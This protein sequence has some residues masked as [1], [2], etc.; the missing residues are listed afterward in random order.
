MYCIG[1]FKEVL[2]L[3][4]CD[5]FSIP[6]S[7]LY[8]IQETSCDE[9]PVDEDWGDVVAVRALDDLIVAVFTSV[10]MPLV[11]GLLGLIK[12]KKSLSQI[13]MDQLATT[14]DHK[15]INRIG[16]YQKLQ[17]QKGDK[18]FFPLWFFSILGCVKWVHRESVFNQL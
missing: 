2:F 18:F 12:L 10:I 4:D 9:L 16:W 17:I 13:S 7:W 14:L 15:V 1:R 6:L 11:I 8:T 3:G 5:S